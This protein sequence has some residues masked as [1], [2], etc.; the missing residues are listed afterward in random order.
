[1]TDLSVILISKNQDWNIAR[2]IESVLREAAH[3]PSVEIML[4]DS[5]SIDRTTE[6]AAQFPI[7]VLKL[8]PDQH[9]SASAGRYV[10]I[11][12]TTGDLVLFLDGDMELYSGWLD[13]AIEVMSTRP[14]VGVVCGRVIDRPKEMQTSNLERKEN[15]PVNDGEIISVQH[16][17]GA[18]LYRRSIL[19][20]VATFNPYLFSDE[21]PSLCLQIRH[22]GFKILR[23]PRPIVFHYTVPW[24]ALTTFLD[25]RKS[26]IWIGYGQNLRY[27]SGTPYLLP[28]LKERGWA[29][30]PAILLMLG[31]AALMVSLVTGQ[32]G[33][34]ALWVALSGLIFLGIAIRE[35]SLERAFLILFRRFLILDGTIRGYLLKTHDPAGYPGRFDKIR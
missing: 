28:Y 31:L 26:M 7:S 18:S 22:A 33:W 27:F 24:E 3:H 34:F 23:L 5:A 15:L 6:I 19:N 30:Q 8:H 16:G 35:R 14:D 29:I 25:K 10:G 21:E 11:K 2:L 20:E 32:W 17:G 4:V 12:H 1:M 13:K 9:L